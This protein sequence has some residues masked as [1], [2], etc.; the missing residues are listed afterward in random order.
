M[1]WHCEWWYKCVY[2]YNLK[3]SCAALGVAL[4]RILRR[5]RP[6]LLLYFNLHLTFISEESDISGL[7]N[8]FREDYLYCRQ[9]KLYSCFSGIECLYFNSVASKVEFSSPVYFTSQIMN[10]NGCI[11]LNNFKAAKGTNPYKIVHA[12]FVACTSFEAR[13]YKVS[14]HVTQ[15]ERYLVVLWPFYASQIVEHWFYL[16]S[17]LNYGDINYFYVL[18][19]SRRFICLATDFVISWL[20]IFDLIT[21]VL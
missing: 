3:V 7:S 17:S 10:D 9:V 6:H 20:V 12:F 19:Y 21:A 1:K 16:S 8:I 2:I 4:L 13:R 14:F 5:T 15:F 18:I 11:H